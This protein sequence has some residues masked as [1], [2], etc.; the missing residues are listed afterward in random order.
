MVD[1]KQSLPF[2]PVVI[3]GAARSGTNMLRDILTKL[4]GFRTWPCD[5]IPS[6]GRYGNRDYPD[7]ELPPELA[8]PKVRRYVRGAFKSAAERDTEFLV[9]KTCASSLRSAYIDAILPEA[10]FLYIVR[11][12]RDAV[13]SAMKRWRSS[14]DL[15]Y[16]LRKARFVPAADIPHLAIRFVTNRLTR[17]WSKEKRL[18]VWGPVFRGMRDLPADTDLMELAALQWQR[19]IDISDRELSA[20]GDNRVHAL[21]YEEFVSNPVDEMM[22]ICDFLGTPR[23]QGDLTTATANVR[24]DSV[25]KARKSLS[26]EQLALLTEMLSGTLERHAR[27]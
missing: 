20:L 11:D 2:M 10:R 25:G 12:G 22:R 14:F 21:T 15:M 19:C 7:D 3:I 1:E 8:I 4:S 26:D 17:G 24:R 9:E 13:A 27:G 5:E 18:G 6:I 16:S 23:S